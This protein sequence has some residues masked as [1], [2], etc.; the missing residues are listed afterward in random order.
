MPK[1]TLTY[2]DLT[3]EALIRISVIADQLNVTPKRAREIYLLELA[4]SARQLAPA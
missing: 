1:V 2:S 4:R 3:K